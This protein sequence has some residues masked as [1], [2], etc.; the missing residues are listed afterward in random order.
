MLI[1]MT[2]EKIII[3]Y[4]FIFLFFCRKGSFKDALDGVG[5]IITSVNTLNDPPKDVWHWS[6]SARHLC[7]LWAAFLK[8]KHSWVS[9]CIG[10]IITLSFSWSLF[11][12][13]VGWGVSLFW[14]K[15]KWLTLGMTRLIHQYPK[16]ESFLAGNHTQ[17][18]SISLV[19]HPAVRSFPREWDLEGPKMRV[20]Q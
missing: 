9:C 1:Q 2:K 6:V 20:E 12:L 10:P 5:L 18:S 15:S 4:P 3:F 8:I 13:Q 11:G 7:T 19:W 14:Q 16:A 17:P